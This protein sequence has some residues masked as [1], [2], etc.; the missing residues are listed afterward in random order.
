VKNKEKFESVILPKYFKHRKFSSFVRQLNMY[1]F[2][3]LRK[4][5]EIPIFRHKYFRMNKRE[6]LKKIKR[7]CIEDGDNNDK[8]EGESVNQKSK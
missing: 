8:D 4:E 1:D 5:K 7:R 6:L 3:K 2:H